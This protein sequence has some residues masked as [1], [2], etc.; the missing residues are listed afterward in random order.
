MGRAGGA[1]IVAERALI[2]PN[3]RES[4]A[5]AT[6]PFYHNRLVRSIEAGGE[7]NSLPAGDC[8]VMGTIGYE[9]FEGIDVVYCR[10]ETGNKRVYGGEGIEGAEVGGKSLTAGDAGAAWEVVM[11]ANLMNGNRDQYMR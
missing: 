8:T 2:R 6:H 5:V 9:C 3:S 4:N 7:A 11:G 10:G 1:V